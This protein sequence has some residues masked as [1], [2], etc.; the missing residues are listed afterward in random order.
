MAVPEG[1][2][3]HRLS[4][5]LY[6]TFGGSPVQATSPQGRFSE[7][8]AFVDGRPL[9]RSTARGK[10]LFLEFDE[11]L[12]HIHLG[13]I[14]KFRPRPFDVPAGESVRLNLANGGEDWQLTGPQTCAVINRAEEAAITDKLGPDPLARGAKADRFVEQL[15]R[16]SAPIAAVLLD[17]AVIAGIGNVY[18]AEF[19]FL[20]GID[21]HTPAKQLPTDQAVTLWNLASD[22][23]RV[24]VKLNRIVTV[25]RQDA[26]M[27]L[28]RVA[29]D[30]RLY[31]YK[32]EDQ[33]CRH[34]D[35]PISIGKVGGRSVWWCHV[36]QPA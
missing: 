5:D 3:I 20:L 32:R 23:L 33:P 4:R 22:L 9:T 15:A 21:P 24:G 17:Q 8:A 29:N 25:S 11:T 35:A 27:A 26:G 16:K 34:C 28:S 30:D 19:L 13:L 36:C 14:G 18:R 2:T 12:L 7:G 1:H 6:R 31:V 10:H